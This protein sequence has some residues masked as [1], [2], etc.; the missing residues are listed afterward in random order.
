MT[1][2]VRQTSLETHREIAAKGLLKNQR[3]LVYRWLI[4][5]GPCTAGELAQEMSA[6][7]NGLAEIRHMVSRR[8]PELRDRGVAQ[9]VGDR[10]CRVGGRKSIVW[11]AAGAPSTRV[12]PNNRLRPTKAELRAA[13]VELRSLSTLA[14]MN[15]RP[16][17]G[18]LE[19]VAEWLEGK[20]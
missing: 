3:G 12:T 16:F 13:V 17:S 20:T 7:C 4:R 10:V 1:Q 11:D 19:R 15:G 6:H 9:E 5:V 8:L 2:T 18:A 14:A